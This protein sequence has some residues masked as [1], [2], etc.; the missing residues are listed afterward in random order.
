MTAKSTLSVFMLT[1][2]VYDIWMAFQLGSM[3]Y[4]DNDIENKQCDSVSVLV[5]TY[6][7]FL[8]SVFVGIVGRTPLR[9]A[10]GTFNMKLKFFCVLNFI[11]IIICLILII[12]GSISH[13][14]YKRRMT[15]PHKYSSLWWCLPGYTVL[16]LMVALIKFVTSGLLLFMGIAATLP[17]DM[18]DTF[19]E[20]YLSRKAAKEAKKNKKKQTAQK[21]SLDIA[22][23]ESLR[24]SDLANNFDDFE[25]D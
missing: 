15:S 19:L 14:N 9:H 6:V 12:M 1:L 17:S 20:Q 16:G 7:T 8:L 18:D 11:N 25:S 4:H 21:P 24:A 23:L 2:C 5:L 10:N 22:N 13:Q 3:H